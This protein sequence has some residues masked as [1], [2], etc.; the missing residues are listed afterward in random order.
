MSVCRRKRACDSLADISVS[1]AMKNIITRCAPWQ[2][3]LRSGPSED[4]L[5]SGVSVLVLGVAY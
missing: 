5:V 1:G 3:Q 2:E 4:S